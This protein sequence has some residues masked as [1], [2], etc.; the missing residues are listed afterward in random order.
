MSAERK[1]TVTYTGDGAQ[2]TYSFP[3]DYLR[4]A[5]VKVQDI[6][7]DAITEL[8]LGTDY[9]IDDK[10]VTLA[11]AIPSGNHLKIYRQTTTEPL[12]E[13]QD[14]S[15][16]R[17]ADL[18]LQEVQL[19]HLSEE[20]LD[21][22]QEG[23][24]AT[25]PNNSDVWDARFKRMK[26]LLDPK[27][28]GDAMTLRYAKNTTNGMITNITNTG[29]T[30][31]KRVTTTGD[32]QTKRVTDEGNTQNTRVTTTGDTYVTQMTSLKDTATTKA[33][34][35][36]SSADLSKAWA[37]SKT[38]PDGTNSMSSMSWAEASKLSASNAK[39]SE[40]N[41]MSYML[42]ASSSASNAKASETKAN[43]SAVNAK[44]SE[45]KAKTSESNSKVSETNAATSE[46]EAKT[47][48]DNAAKYDPRELI[49]EAYHRIKRD[50]A[51]E[52]GD[53]LTST[54]LPY[55]VVIDV[56]QAGTTGAVEPDWDSIKDDIGNSQAGATSI[57]ELKEQVALLV[58]TG[59][60]MPYAGDTPPKGFLLCNGQAVSRTTYVNLFTAIG[61]KYG[62]GDGNATFNVPNLIDR[63]VEGGSESGA[64]KEAGLP[65]I[66]GSWRGQNWGV[67]NQTYIDGAS[68]SR[69]LNYWIHYD[70]DNTNTSNG[71][72]RYEVTSLDASRQNPVYGKSNTVQPASVVMTY[73]IKA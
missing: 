69:L 23:G 12:V 2:T 56:T 62:E 71:Q 58:P 64:T 65:N 32:T 17:S 14:A 33:T 5:F 45:D 3:F 61:T 73:I 47:H 57:Q 1:A 49:D 70:G 40:T 48:A 26:N 52:V 31:V 46:Q 19:L 66:T 68:I 30:Q 42:N 54:N 4:K 34:E 60:I 6:A 20:T 21:R 41:A 11:K 8:T 25:D 22:V 13:W 38:S 37:V 16:L 39:T 44:A 35:A 51:Y 55:D 59:V 63:F 24:L 7:G 53:V 29:D 27:D 9:S 10:Q 36:S 15:V 67:Y 28:D 50:T 43:A 72:D 18:S